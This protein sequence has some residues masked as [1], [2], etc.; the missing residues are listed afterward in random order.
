MA[1]FLR[2]F[3]LF[4]IYTLAITARRLGRFRRPNAKFRAPSRNVYHP[5]A[6][7]V[8]PPSHNVH[9]K[10]IAKREGDTG[11]TSSDCELRDPSAVTSAEETSL[12]LTSVLTTDAGVTTQT[13][14]DASFTFV[15]PSGFESFSDGADAL[16]FSFPSG[17]AF[18]SGAET[19]TITLPTPTVLPSVFDSVVESTAV[20]T[21]SARSTDSVVSESAAAASVVVTA[22]SSAATESTSVGT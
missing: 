11:T 4:T 6:H 1:I 21:E 12:E 15:L 18:S 22:D 8:H 14:S 20:S 5:L 7:N 13:V 16:T 2:L 3:V 17:I 9:R 10:R 19:L